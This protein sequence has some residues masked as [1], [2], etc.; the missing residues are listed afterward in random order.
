MVEGAKKE[1]RGAHCE[2]KKIFEVLLVGSF[3]KWAG[4]PEAIRNWV[5]EEWGVIEGVK[6]TQLNDTQFLF[7]FV[8]EDLVVKILNEGRRWFDNNFMHLERWKENV[9][10]ADPRSS[11]DMRIV[12]LVGLPEDK[13]GN[14]ET[15]REEGR[16][17]K[18]RISMLRPSK[19]I[20]VVRIWV[21]G[22]A[23]PVGVLYLQ[24]GLD[25][26]ASGVPPPPTDRKCCSDDKSTAGTTLCEGCLGRITTDG[27]VGSSGDLFLAGRGVAEAVEAAPA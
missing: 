6:I 24:W 20:L 25:E 4:S 18:H 9:G 17:A 1:K 19:G 23:T 27:V 10:C 26:E 16:R 13:E 21:V 5:A 2:E 11:G 8:N 12:N 22:P 14:I 3:V 7:R 15:G